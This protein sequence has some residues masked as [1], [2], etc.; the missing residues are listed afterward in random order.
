MVLLELREVPTNKDYPNYQLKEELKIK[1][2]GSSLCPL[3]I[4]NCKL[5][6]GESS[7]KYLSNLQYVIFQS[8]TLSNNQHFTSTSL[9]KQLNIFRELKGT[10]KGIHGYKTKANLVNR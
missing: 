4:S 8:Q 5:I 2:L 6:R 9:P 3:L 7:L 10:H 1:L